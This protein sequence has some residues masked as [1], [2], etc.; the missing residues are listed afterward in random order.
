VTG[1]VVY[2]GS[3]DNTA[4]ALD[5]GTGAERWSFETGDAVE[6]LTVA[7]DV[8]YIASYDHHLYVLDAA[9]GRERWRCATGGPR[10]RRRSF[11]PASSMSGVSTTPS[12]R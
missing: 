2:V 5:A 11:W 4:Y 8:V 6:G 10:G 7:D 3:L 1:G 9:G 12:T